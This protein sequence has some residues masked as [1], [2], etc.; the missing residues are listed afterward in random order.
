[1]NTSQSSVVAGKSQTWV[2]KSTPY[3]NAWIVIGIIVVADFAGLHLLD[4][5]V[6]LGS[7]SH[8]VPAFLAI[9]LIIIWIKFRTRFVRN[10]ETKWAVRLLDLANTAQWMIGLAAF[11]TVASILSYLSVAADYPLIDEQLSRIDKVIGFDWV[12]SYQWVR[13]HPTLLFFLNL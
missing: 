13:Q 5:R 4:R 7:V 6:V 9:V 3:L 12:A 10:T 11:C 2:G 1:M 8:K